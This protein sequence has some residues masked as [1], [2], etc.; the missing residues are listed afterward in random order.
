M[1]TIIHTSAGDL[2]EIAPPFAMFGG[3][4]PSEE[5]LDPSTALRPRQ[6]PTHERLRSRPRARCRSHRRNDTSTGGHLRERR[7]GRGS[8]AVQAHADVE[9]PTSQ[10]R[11]TS[12]F[13]LTIAA[14]GERKT[15]A[16]GYAL[17][18]VRERER[19]LRELSK[20]E[21]QEYRNRTEVYDQR[22]PPRLRA[23]EAD[24]QWPR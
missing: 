21:M 22:A 6:R 17:Q 14:S 3:A 2:P 8:L 16:D 5:R 18:G 9:L 15:T 7:A 10:V 4:S 20:A 19:E 13:I 24:A 11:P 1:S 23:R 12:L